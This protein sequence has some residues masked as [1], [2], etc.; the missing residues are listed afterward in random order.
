[1][2][3]KVK[4]VMQMLT[5]IFYYF[6]YAIESRL[7]PNAVNS[8]FLTQAISWALCWFVAAVTVISGV[9]Y[10]WDNRTFINTAK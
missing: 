7:D 3:G 8:V 4:T 6:G 5:I 2:W 10:L 1:M 9:K